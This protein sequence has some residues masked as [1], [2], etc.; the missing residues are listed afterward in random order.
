MSPALTCAALLM[1]S[2]L[3]QASGP[4]IPTDKVNAALAIEDVALGEGQAFQGLLRNDNG[5][6][7][8]GAEVTISQLGKE[9][10]RTQ[11]DEQGRFEFQGLR[12]GL[13]LVHAGEGAGLYRLWAKGTAPP[14]ARDNVTMTDSVTIRGQ[15]PIKDLLTSNAMILTGI[16]VAAIVIPI[17]VHN[18]GNDKKSGS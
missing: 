17:A 12:G 8:A 3:C 9:V 1:P 10:A 11:T 2:S 6:P 15:R 18:S 7:V 16:V 4:A 14:H 5:R 13:H